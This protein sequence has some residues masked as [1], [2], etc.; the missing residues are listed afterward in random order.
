[1]E[2]KKDIEYAY[3]LFLCLEN[4]KPTEK[5]MEALLHFIEKHDFNYEKLPTKLRNYV[6]QFYFENSLAGQIF[7]GEGRD[8]L[9]KE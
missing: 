1:M 7:F 9:S 8:E 5:L 4:I 6:A 3:I 2:N